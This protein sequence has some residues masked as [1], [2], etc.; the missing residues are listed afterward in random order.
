MVYLLIE[1]YLVLDLHSGY[2]NLFLCLYLEVL[3]PNPLS[4]NRY[5]G[6]CIRWFLFFCLFHMKSS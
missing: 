3:E 5:Y 2:E 4:K 6:F 1:F